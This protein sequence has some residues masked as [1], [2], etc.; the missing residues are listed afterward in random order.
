MNLSIKD[1]KI[2]TAIVCLLMFICMLAYLYTAHK[3][4]QELSLKTCQ[5]LEVVQTLTDEQKETVKKKLSTAKYDGTVV[6][7]KQE[8]TATIEREQ[9]FRKADTAIVIE[10]PNNVELKQY[11]I[12][13]YPKTQ[14]EVGLK[15]SSDKKISGV[16]YGVRKRI[17]E[18]GKYIGVR[19]DYDWKNKKCGTWLT[20]SW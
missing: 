20:Y 19:L 2:V 3:Q 4:E 12:Y 16:S 17:T 8:L 14:K 7:S 6:T 1:K 10:E 5:K 11:N 9:T 15:F 18:K 13:A